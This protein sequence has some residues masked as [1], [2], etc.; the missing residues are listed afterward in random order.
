MEWRRCVQCDRYE[1]SSSGD[2]RRAAD[3]FPISQWHDRRGYKR[4]T[5]S[6]SGEKKNFM[7]HAL[8]AAAFIREKTSIRETV[9]HIDGNKENNRPENLEWC[10]ISEN[11]RH[12]TIIGLTPRGASHW[13]TSLT[14]EDVRSIR[15]RVAKGESRASLARELGLDKTTIGLMV[16]RKTWGHVA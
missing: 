12:A 8:V 9:N 3:K 1:I 10:S 5:L 7:I 16:S 13:K 14:D 2:V 6:R 15:R 4:V 11:R